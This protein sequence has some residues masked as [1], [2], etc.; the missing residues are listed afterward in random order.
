MGYEIK[1]VLPAGARIDGIEA[2]GLDAEFNL[3]VDHNPVIGRLA[4]STPELIVEKMAS[5]YQLE[6]FKHLNERLKRV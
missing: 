4:N 2:K 5:L 6:Y 1:E 3:I